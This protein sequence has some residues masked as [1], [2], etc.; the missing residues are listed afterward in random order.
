MSET[1]QRKA[2]FG[3][4]GLVLAGALFGIIPSLLVTFWQVRLQTHQ[5]L[6]NRQLTVIQDLQRTMDGLIVES[7]IA[8]RDLRAHGDEYCSVAPESMARPTTPRSSL[9]RQLLFS[10]VDRSFEDLQRTVA[11]RRVELNG[12]I[13]L[14][15]A[16]FKT[17]IKPL[18]V[19]GTLRP[20]PPAHK[21]PG[22]LEAGAEEVRALCRDQ[23]QAIT[24]FAQLSAEREKLYQELLDILIAKVGKE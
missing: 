10:E 16:L 19:S 23:T 2:Y 6:L 24:E 18:S 3:Q 13:A 7:E 20:K 14:A 17:N 15:N 12:Q 21:R 8:M 5:L 11:R 1:N 4:I 9:E 22:S